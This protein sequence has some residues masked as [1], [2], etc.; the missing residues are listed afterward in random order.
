MSAG[1]PG[2]RSGR[3]E[4][5]AGCP[6]TRSKPLLL[7]RRDAGAFACAPARPGSGHPCGRA[8]GRSSFGKTPSLGHRRGPMLLRNHAAAAPRSSRRRVRPAAVGRPVVRS[9]QCRLA[10]CSLARSHYPAR[11]P[12]RQR[13]GL[14]SAWTRL[15]GRPVGSPLRAQRGGHTP[16]CP[17]PAA[18]CPCRALKRSG[19][20][21]LT[22]QLAGLEVRAAALPD[23]PA[24]E[25]LFGR[26]PVAARAGAGFRTRT[27]V[28]RCAPP[29]SADGDAGPVRAWWC[30]LR[31]CCAA[32][33]P[34]HFPGA[35]LP[36]APPSKVVPC[37]AVKRMR[38]RSTP[39]RQQARNAP[40][41]T[42]V[43]GT[44]TRGGHRRAPRHAGRRS[45]ASTARH[46]RTSGCWRRSVDGCGPR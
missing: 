9:G 6:R 8:V 16:G 39:E 18:E 42:L 20:R 40:A 24:A 14:P 45:G 34:M 7:R 32:R 19:L 31:E 38:Q 22:R 4:P 46:G 12:L 1:L 21:R 27:L 25:H 11:P 13:R 2:K 23:G 43:S 15:R 41:A 44:R 17:T 36:R 10:A 3:R 30:R 35:G 28:C 33:L 5:A 37:R 26:R 29:D